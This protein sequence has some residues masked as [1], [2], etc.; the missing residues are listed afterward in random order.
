MPRTLIRT[1][2]KPVRRLR[3]TGPLLVDDHPQLAVS[4]KKRTDQAGYKYRHLP[5][6][7][8]TFPHSFPHIK[9]AILYPLQNQLSAL[10]TPPTNTT[11]NL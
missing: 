7:H 4:H 2:G 9:S 11:T 6:L 3:R 10:S 1:W 5:T 8:P